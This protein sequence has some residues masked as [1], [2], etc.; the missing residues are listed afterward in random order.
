MS[1]SWRARI[2]RTATSPRF[3]TRTRL[4]RI[5][6]PAEH[7]L[8]LEQE[9]A[10]LDRV[11]VRDVDPADDAVEVGLDLVH[12]LHRLEDAERLAGKDRRSLLH[13]RWRP[14]RGRPVEGPDHRR[15]DADDTVGRRLERGRRDI[16]LRRSGRRRSGSRHT[17]VGLLAT[18]DRDAHA[19]L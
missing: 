1:S 8:D 18:P 6:R 13:E 14:G 17:R 12:Q 4:N 19:G 11:A 3:A 16:L 5:E 9:L 15:L 10:E 7:R 2:T